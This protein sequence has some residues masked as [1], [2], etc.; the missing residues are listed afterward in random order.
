MTNATFLNLME[1]LPGKM[2]LEKFAESGQMSIHAMRFR[3]MSDRPL[4]D[5]YCEVLKKVMS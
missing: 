1:T 5:Y 2:L 3:L 4:A